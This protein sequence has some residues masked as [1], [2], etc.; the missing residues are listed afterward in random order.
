MMKE[1]RIKKAS[2]DFISNIFASSLMSIVLQLVIYPLF[3][4]KLSSGQYGLI[5][6]VMGVV[7][8]FIGA[9]GNSLNNVR[10]VCNNQYGQN[11]NGDFNILLAIGSMVAMSFCLLVMKIYLEMSFDTSIL[12]LLALFLGILRSYYCVSFRLILDFK[13]VFFC[14]LCISAGY[15]AGG[16]AF[17]LLGKWILVFIIGELAGLIYLKKHSFVVS[18]ELHSTS[19][20][21]ETS[22]VYMNFA[23]AAL[24][25]SAIIYLDRLFILPVLGAGNVAVYSVSSVF[26]KTIGMAM[27]PVAGVLLGYFAQKEFYMSRKIFNIISGF[28]FIVCALF[29]VVSLMLSKPVIGILYPSL[30]NSAKQYM[31]LANLAAIMEVFS[32][33]LSPIILKYSKPYW[34][35]TVSIVYGGLFCSLGIYFSL[36]YALLGFCYAALIA[37]GIR[38]AI[39]YII[40]WRYVNENRL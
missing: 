26:G 28:S 27:L 5:L 3:S 23:G 8:T 9:A 34:Q 15:L 22:K 19:K 31:H 36:K 29:Y 17:C 18:T 2:I 25:G 20:L 33:M 11:E 10:L 7:N 30:V 37:N 14:N 32:G 6:A 12:V 35:L 39:L 40:G 24:I 13:K 21:G 16:M 1:K 4:M 38:A